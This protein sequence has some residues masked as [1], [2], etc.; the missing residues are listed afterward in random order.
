[1]ASNDKSEGPQ[2]GQVVLYNNGGTIV[3]AIIYAVATAGT[4]SL[5]YF[6]ASGAT[7]VTGV[8]YDSGFGGTGLPSSR[9][10]YMP[11]L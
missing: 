11:Y 9:W 1:M 5:N 8:G 6:N 10:T 2:V 4:V 3:P 7:N